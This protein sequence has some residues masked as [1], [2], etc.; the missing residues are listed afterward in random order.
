[1]QLRNR[2]VLGTEFGGGGSEV[3][4]MVEDEDDSM[5]QVRR[6]AGSMEVGQSDAS[7]GEQGSAEARGLGDKENKT[8]GRI[9]AP[10]SAWRVFLAWMVHLYTS[11]GLI[12]DFCAI[13]YIINRD[14]AMFCGLNW[15]A[16]IIDATDGTAARAVGV[17]KVIPTFD[18]ASLDNIIDF[19]TFSFLPSLAAMSFELVPRPAWFI[20]TVLPLLASCYQF[21]QT[22]AKTDQAFVGFPSYWNLVFFY[23]YLLRPPT[24]VILGIYILC[25]VLSFFPFH[26]VYPSRT[27]HW[28]RVTLFLGAIWAVMMMMPVILPAWHFSRHMLLGSLLYVVYYTVLSVYLHGRKFW[29]AKPS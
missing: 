1:M 22:V 13:H 17:K 23:M 15:L 16:I 29:W 25:T 8:Q 11:S 10:Y 4:G 5:R 26:F 28:R 19:I 3:S 21:C 7:E 9:P 2:K 27:S 20:V 14:F 12:V 24:W 6:R 18:G